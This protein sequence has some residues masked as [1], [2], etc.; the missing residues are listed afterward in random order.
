ML[1]EPIYGVHGHVPCSAKCRE[2]CCS[3]W[4]WLTEGVGASRRLSVLHE[5]TER[6]HGGT[7]CFPNTL[8][9]AQTHIQASR[10]DVMLDRVS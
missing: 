8:H 6:A 2:G 5:L 9:H 7:L 10:S 4:R 3:V 1:H